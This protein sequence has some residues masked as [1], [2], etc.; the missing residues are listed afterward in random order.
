MKS[1]MLPAFYVLFLNSIPGNISIF[2]I[3]FISHFLNTVFLLGSLKFHIFSL[4][5]FLRW[6]VLSVWSRP[7]WQNFYHL[8]TFTISTYDTS[9]R[10]SKFISISD[11]WTAHLFDTIA[12][13]WQPKWWRMGEKQGR[14][15][16]THGEELAQAMEIQIIVWFLTESQTCPLI[17]S[18]FTRLH[19]LASVNDRGKTEFGV[20]IRRGTKVDLSCHC[21]WLR[22]QDADN[23][24]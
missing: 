9:P 14:V 5:S 16:P 7:L 13:G 11:N 21:R 24:D 4:F 2:C 19:R 20:Y 15:H 3:T 18:F 1:S 17:N 10:S 6:N 22:I 8:S 12:A 23:T